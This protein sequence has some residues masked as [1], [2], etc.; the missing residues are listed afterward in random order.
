MKKEVIGK[1]PIC[2]SKMK[3]T[4]VKCKTCKTTISGE[5]ELCKFC[6][7]NKEHKFF[8]E[9]FIKNRGNIKLIEKELGVSYPTVKRN[10]NE[11]IEALGYSPDKAEEKEA[12]RDVLD[13]LERGEISS[14]EA[15]E[16]LKG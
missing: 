2:S 3:V 9:I 13:K 4:E 14:K 12:K 16:L 11:V 6:N 10:L 1:C 5:F 15:L 7:L 8:I